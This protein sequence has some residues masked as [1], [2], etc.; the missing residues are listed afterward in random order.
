MTNRRRSILMLAAVLFAAAAPALAT[1][2]SKRFV[3]CYD[4]R[5]D[6]WGQV[7]DATGVA[8]AAVDCAQKTDPEAFL[9]GHVFRT[10]D[11]VL[12][13]VLN[14][15]Y[16]VA[17]S[18][19]VAGT[20]LAPP[21]GPLIFGGESLKPITA[22]GAT[23]TPLLLVPLKTALQGGPDAIDN[24]VVNGAGTHQAADFKKLLK[25]RVK[26]L[27][28]LAQLR[29]A[30][31]RE[32]QGTFDAL[33]TA[34]T[35]IGPELHALEEK[36][37]TSLDTL[38]G[39]PPSTPA[40]LIKKRGE[41]R[42]NLRERKRVQDLLQV[43]SLPQNVARL[44]QIRI[45]L[46]SDELAPVVAVTDV[47]HLKLLR[48]IRTRERGVI[49]TVT[50]SGLGCDGP[51]CAPKLG[52]LVAHVADSTANPQAT[53]LAKM[54]VNL[55]ELFKRENWDP[56]SELIDAVERIKDYEQKAA[57]LTDST[58]GDLLMA[59]GKGG[60]TQ[61]GAL[62]RGI[63][64]ATVG[65]IA[66]LNH[67]PAGIDYPSDLLSVGRWNKAKVITLTVKKQARFTPFTFQRFVSA[68]PQTPPTA[69]AE[70]TPEP[71][72]SA[73]PVPV[74]TRVFEVH[75]TYHLRMTAGFIYSGLDDPDYGQGTRMVPDPDGAMDAE[76][77]VKEITE[78][79]PVLKRN[80]DYRV[81]PTVNLLIYPQGVDFF[82]GR[83]PK[84][85]VAGLVGVSLT[86]PTKSWLFGGN[87]QLGDVFNINGGL[88]LGFVE[89]LPNGTEVG[90]ALEPGLPVIVDE[91]LKTS[92]FVG[93][94]VSPSV[95][96]TLF[97][98]LF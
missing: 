54:K 6:E 37:K 56:F 12:L 77:N 53:V 9:D 96:T 26:P 82:P 21:D 92:G 29:T 34:R 48:E 71:R 69:I 8:D 42:E 3:I 25:D 22:F 14:G 43:H 44:A 23:A 47:T 1:K 36:L 86:N 60:T 81:E 31:N 27:Y 30:S 5:V 24:L 70:Q 2:G 57:D 17:L 63:D 11:E 40:G 84:V 75:H 62:I 95:F 32:N 87:L 51:G 13:K 89:E 68:N 98:E 49:A 58:S 50:A 83:H 93:F 74:A 65:L 33:Q 67:L 61:L 15:K 72:T 19:A 80:R 97:S 66:A 46:Q 64:A 7:L 45:A 41:F 16:D 85:A 4:A 88:H 20:D 79:I 39:S 90:K 59:D 76:G 38:T 55:P 35:E 73:T 91:K 10:G 18:L 94:S 28:T 78:V 52:E